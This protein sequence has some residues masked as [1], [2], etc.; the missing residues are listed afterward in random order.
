MTNQMKSKGYSELS[1][2][3]TFEDRYNYLKVNNVVGCETF[4]YDRYLNQKFYTSAEWKRVRNEV[5]IRDNGCDMGLPG[6]PIRGKI[7]IH[8]IEPL[9][10]DDVANNSYKMLDPN[11][12]V[13]VS[14]STHNA[15]HY[16]DETIVKDKVIVERT[17]NDT[18]LWRT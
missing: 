10:L 4:G 5:I 16:G 18:T 2:L 12:L 1:Q 8:H 6:Y 9:T 13:C 7:Y 14:Q 11:N 17:P 15:I 3:S